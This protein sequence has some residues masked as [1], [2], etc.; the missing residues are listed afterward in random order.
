MSKFGKWIVEN[1][2]SQVWKKIIKGERGVVFMIYARL[3]DFFSVYL[4]FENK[5]QERNVFG[6]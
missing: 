4:I 1:K 2:M 5:K 3:R 6:F